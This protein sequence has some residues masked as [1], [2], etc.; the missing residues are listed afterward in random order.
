[1]KKPVLRLQLNGDSEIIEIENMFWEKGGSYAYN[2]K[3][4]GED[5]V[6]FA[7]KLLNKDI[8][9]WKGLNQTKF[10]IRYTDQWEEKLNGYK[11]YSLIPL[12]N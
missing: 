5:K 12:K 1:M 3:H 4:N 6:L 2:I 8:E 10:K 11:M 7:T 9:H